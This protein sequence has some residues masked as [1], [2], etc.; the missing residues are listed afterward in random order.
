[1]NNLPAQRLKMFPGQGE[2]EAEKL[3]APR[4]LQKTPITTNNTTTFTTQLR[5]LVT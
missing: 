3:Q 5:F 2:G 1:M 4:H